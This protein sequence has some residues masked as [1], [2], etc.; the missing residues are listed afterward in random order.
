MGRLTL[1]MR[2]FFEKVLLDQRCQLLEE[3]E[4]SPSREGVE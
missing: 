1:N 4:D 2:I 3:Q